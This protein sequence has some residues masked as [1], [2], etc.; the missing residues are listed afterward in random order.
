MNDRPKIEWI[1]V[2][3]NDKTNRVLCEF[4]AQEAEESFFSFT[5]PDGKM[6]K[7]FLSPIGHELI[8]RL[9]KLAV[10]NNEI[11]FEVYKK[12]GDKITRFSF[13]ELRKSKRKKQ[14]AGLKKGSD[15]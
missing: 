3:L 12:K 15:L 11:Q 6:K 1:A 13:S 10:G 14:L 4:L 5:A 2:P 7:G 8:T 9:K